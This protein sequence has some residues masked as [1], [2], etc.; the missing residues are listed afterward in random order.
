MTLLMLL[1]IINYTTPLYEL[2]NFTSYRTEALYKLYELYKLY[3]LM[4]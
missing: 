1:I 2:I 4:H 3:K